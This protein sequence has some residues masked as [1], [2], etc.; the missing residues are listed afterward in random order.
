[1]AGAG[2]YNLH[3]APQ[4]VAGRFGLDL[5]EAAARNVPLDAARGVVIA[6]YGS[7]QGRNSLVP[8]AAAIAAVRARVAASTAISVVHTDLPENDFAALFT[9]LRDDPH[10]YM[11]TDAAVFSFA[12]GRSFYEQLLPSATV[13]LG[14]T[15]ITVHWLSAAPTAIRRHIFSPLA[16]TDERAAY[17]DRAANDWTQFLL[18]RC[19][20]LVPG[21]GL[22]VVGSGADDGGRSGAEG[23]LDLANDVLVRMVN[24][25]QLA[26]EVY[27]RMVI[28]T[29][30]RT[31]EEFLAGLSAAPL[32]EAFELESCSES[33][34]SDPLWAEFQRTGDLDTYA[35]AVSDFT[36]AFTEPSLFGPVAA[37]GPLQATADE[38]YA[39]LAQTI[40]RHPDQAASN[41]H[42]VLLSI[43]RRCTPAR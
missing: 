37:R 18:H 15:S 29:Y 28:P 1:M 7:S 25:G 5:L 42:L 27:E 16:A 30:Y 3:S 9:T 10:S 6:D 31:R 19:A 41:W 40:K 2:Q 24:D 8:M 20:E 26:P 39:R 4:H 12:S 38:F 22:V 13:S 14:W 11:R 35:S 32:A 36:R 21:G 34:L 43:R 23:L 17:A 33:A